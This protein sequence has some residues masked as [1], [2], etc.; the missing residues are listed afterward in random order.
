MSWFSRCRAGPIGVTRDDE[1]L[2]GLTLRRR[3]RRRSELLE[4]P[5]LPPPSSPFSPYGEH[6]VSRVD[7]ST[8]WLPRVRTFL[9]LSPCARARARIRLLF[10]IE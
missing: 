9:Q 7:V 3:R 5:L 4:E 8:R 1:S 2:V 6:T 10:G